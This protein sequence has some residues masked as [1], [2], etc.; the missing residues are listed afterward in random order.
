M[1]EPLVAVI[2]PTYNGARYLADTM[3]SVQQQTWPN[4]IHVVLDNNSRDE[5][6]E[7]VKRYS[8]K[9]VPVMYFRNDTPL[10]QRDNWNK[11]FSLAPLEAEYV[12]LLCDDDTIYRHSIE[13]MVQ[14]AG[15]DPTIGVVGSRDD[16]HLKDF[17]WPE[18]RQIFDGREALAKALLGEGVIMPVQ[19]MWRKAVADQRQPLFDD[20][21][22]GGA[23]DMDTV[24]DLLTRSKFGFI[25]E[26]LGFT[27]AHSNSVSNLVY[28]EKSHSNTRDHF[29][30][31]L[32][33]GP[34]ALGSD[35]DKQLTRFRRIYVRQ[36]LMWW[37]EDRQGVQLGSHFRALERAGR[38]F[39]I[40]LIADAIADWV[41][42]KIHIRNYSDSFTAP[43]RL[44]DPLPR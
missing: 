39:G 32:K 4:I 37:R 8:K 35:Y 11:A 43:N 23:F 15:T 21:I 16:G 29:D 42:R 3:E 18:S 24:F 30:L 10:A 1:P 19:M 33:Y 38:P 9:R 36:I 14:L 44:R 26:T 25:H 28:G 12:R 20:Y 6:P 2:T 34:V 5:T 27:R 31:F 17:R 40:S 41:L 13:K 7:I 22:E